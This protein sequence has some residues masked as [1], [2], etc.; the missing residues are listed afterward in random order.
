MPANSRSDLLITRAYSK[1]GMDKVANSEVEKFLF[2]KDGQLANETPTPE[3]CLPIIPT[4]HCKE[5]QSGIDDQMDNIPVQSDLSEG[6]GAHLSG[7]DVQSHSP[8]PISVESAHDEPS[9]VH[10]VDM[11]H[12]IQMPLPVPLR[13]S[14]RQRQLPNRLNDYYCDV[15]IQNR[16][17]PH[18]ISKKSKV[19][20]NRL[21][22]L[23]S[24]MK[25][26]K[27]KRMITREGYFYTL[28]SAF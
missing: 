8:I 28:F 26:E 21:L 16:T 3:P 15:V 17:S 6:S 19:D 9:N 23:D 24:M 1:R 20:D 4:S 2:D 11:D 14:N 12:E 10:T 22:G 5:F 7:N 18:A 25:K 27:A 13:R